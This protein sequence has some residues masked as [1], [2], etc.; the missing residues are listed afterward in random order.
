MKRLLQFGWVLFAV[1]CLLPAGP[2]PTAAFVLE[3]RQVLELM[4]RQ[5]NKLESLQVS[6]TLVVHGGSPD[7][8]SAEFAETIAYQ[9]PDRFRSEITGL[10]HERLHVVNR[11]AALTVT[12]GVLTAEAET[13]A[14][15][16]KD[17]LLHRDRVR[18]QNQLIRLGVDITVTSFGRLE[19][20]TAFVI[21]A[22]YPDLSAPQVW[23]DQRS[24]RPVRLILP[25]APY[26]RD[27]DALDIRFQ[28][29]R[30]TNAV[31]YPWHILFYRGERLEREFKITRVE[32]NPSFPADFFDL[33][34]LKARYRPAPSASPAPEAPPA[35]ADVQKTLDDFK[36][37]FD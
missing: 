14:D 15:R 35:G 3:G 21:G 4:A 20:E 31:W 34:R 23:I 8:P 37:I 27:P 16:Y 28:N 9:F 24:F 2:G 1:F 17:L 18:L 11:D 12:D 25:A 6:Q 10:N 13:A 5:Q 29:W 30:D 7:D 32:P 33:G 22:R 26:S 36:K 19:T